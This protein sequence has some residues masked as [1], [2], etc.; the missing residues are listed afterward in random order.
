LAAAAAGADDSTIMDRGRPLVA[1]VD[2]E[3]SVRKALRRLLAASDMECTLFASGR[4]FLDS[5][6]RRL[7]DCALLDLR[8]SGL[9]GLDVQRELAA[10]GWKVPVIII[11]AHDEPARRAQCLSAGAVEYLRKPLDDEVLLLAIGKAVG[12]RYWDTH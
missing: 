6:G 10:A 2:D 1:I 7:P 5:L 12:T 3:A 4:D 11:T 8:M 9:S